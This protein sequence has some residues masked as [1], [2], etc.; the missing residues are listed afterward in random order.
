MFADTLRPRASLSLRVVVVADVVVRPAGLYCS[1][2][3]GGLGSGYVDVGRVVCARPYMGDEEFGVGVDPVKWVGGLLVLSEMG[4]D[5]GDDGTPFVV[6]DEGVAGDPFD[7]EEDGWA[8]AEVV[9]VAEATDGTVNRKG[10]SEISEGGEVFFECCVWFFNCRERA[11]LVVELKV[12]SCCH[13]PR[14]AFFF[15]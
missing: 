5:V 15:G 1:L 12:G 9:D 14:G 8:E 4:N 3:Y 7:V 11:R 2:F 10:V 13:F 6:A